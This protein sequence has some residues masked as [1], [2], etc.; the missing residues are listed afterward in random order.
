MPALRELVPELNVYSLIPILVSLAFIYVGYRALKLRVKEQVSICVQQKME[1]R[2][3][4]SFLKYIGTWCV[5]FSF[6]LAVFFVGMKVY[7]TSAPC[8]KKSL[9]DFNSI[10]LQAMTYSGIG[11]IMAILGY[12]WNSAYDRLGQIVK[13]LAKLKADSSTEKSRRAAEAFEDV[14]STFIF[15]ERLRECFDGPF[16]FFAKLTLFCLTLQAVA[17]FL[18]ST[19]TYDWILWVAILLVSGVFL[20]FFLMLL[21]YYHELQPELHRHTVSIHKLESDP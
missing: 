4:Q 16:W 7:W 13:D 12:F 3:S 1:L 18:P 2:A 8:L 15:L 14:R 21:A 10:A 5:L 9:R 20:W 6:V 11:V 17:H 19:H